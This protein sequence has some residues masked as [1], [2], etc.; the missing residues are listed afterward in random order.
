MKNLIHSVLFIIILSNCLY[1]QNINSASSK[2]PKSKILASTIG[3]T[4]TIAPPFLGY[5]LE[6]NQKHNLAEWVMWYGLLAGPSMGNYYAQDMKRFYIGTGLRTG[7]A[8]L[9]LNIFND[10]EGEDVA[11]G[12]MT[13]VFLTT[14]IWN[15]WKTPKSVQEYNDKNINLSLAPCYLPQSRSVGIALNLNF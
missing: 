5:Y 8:L 13:T 4:N 2:T 10:N 1:S 12:V 6:K 11:V 9:Y 15:L 3:I 14:A 7:T